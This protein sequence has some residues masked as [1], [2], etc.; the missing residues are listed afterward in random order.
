MNVAQQLAQARADFTALDSYTGKLE[1]NLA[2]QNAELERLR[3]EARSGAAKFD[4]VVKQQTRREAAQGMLRQHLDDLAQ[5]QALV[6]ELEAAQG[7]ASNLS[8]AQSAFARLR[9]LEAQHAA[10]SA[11]VESYL[12]EHLSKLEALEAEHGTAQA[13]LA[14]AVLTFTGKLERLSEQE[15]RQLLGSIR[16]RQPSE[17]HRPA[18]EAVRD[19]LAQV[20]GEHTAQAEELAWVQFYSPPRLTPPTLGDDVPRLKRARYGHL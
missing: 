16:R 3:R 10:L 20:A 8:A 2:E 13:E 5:A 11:Q 15:A 4:D 1:K 7:E 18:L 17:A 14:R 12:S 9:E 6:D 19:F